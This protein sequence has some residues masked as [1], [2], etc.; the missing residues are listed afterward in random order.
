MKRFFFL[1]TVN[2]YCTPVRFL[3]IISGRLL[4]RR[5]ANKIIMYRLMRIFVR[6]PHRIHRCRDNGI[7]VVKRSDFFSLPPPPLSRIKHVNRKK[8]NTLSYSVIQHV[9]SRATHKNR[10][11]K[12]RRV[13]FRKITLRGHVNV[14]RFP[15]DTSESS[16]NRRQSCV[17][18]R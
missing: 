8:N 12:V 17:A 6:F 7:R 18:D 14:F 16:S 15:S 4:L 5:Y 13:E 11:K 3:R 9:V 10:H 1:A 2:A